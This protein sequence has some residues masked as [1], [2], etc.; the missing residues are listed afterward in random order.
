LA[1]SQELLRELPFLTG[2][3]HRV[4][5]SLGTVPSCRGRR[6]P[7]QAFVQPGCEFMEF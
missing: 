6:R 5:R 1:S 7:A 4:P 2:F 3:D